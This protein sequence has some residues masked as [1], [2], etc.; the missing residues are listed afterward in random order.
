MASNPGDTKVKCKE[1]IYVGLSIPVSLMIFVGGKIYSRAT[2]HNGK[3]STYH[4]Y[5]E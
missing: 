3:F 1:F 4:K 2:N 5:V